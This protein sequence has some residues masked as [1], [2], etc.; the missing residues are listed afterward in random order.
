M[1]I[2]VK[3][4][5]EFDIRFNSPLK[6]SG[7][8]GNLLKWFQNYLYGREQRVIINCSNS[9]WLPV[10]AGVLH[11]S[12]LDPILFKICLNDIVRE[13]N[14][15]IKLFSDDTSLYLIVNNPNDTAFLP[16][17]RSQSITTLV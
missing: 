9:N 10:R 14:A 5:I 13:I 16:E 17:P 11:G 6:Q 12:I 15:E 3:H 1:A 2:S 4:L 7:I 8:S